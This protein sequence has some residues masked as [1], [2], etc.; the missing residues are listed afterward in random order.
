MIDAIRKRT[1]FPELSVLVDSLFLGGELLNQE[2]V[3]TK[4][5]LIITFQLIQFLLPEGKFLR[6]RR[7]VRLGFSFFCFL[8]SYFERYRSSFSLLILFIFLSFF[9]GFSLFTCLFLLFV[10]LSVDGI[11][12]VPQSKLVPVENIEN[13]E[14]ELDKA[15]DEES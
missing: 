9:W 13:S 2:F 3:E 6:F 14:D 12:V 11:G 5:L 4:E 10:A 8:F 7:S 15:E 1:F